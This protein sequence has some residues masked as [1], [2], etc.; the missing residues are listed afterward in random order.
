MKKYAIIRTFNIGDLNDFAASTIIKSLYSY[1]SLSDV[2]AIGY[3]LENSIL[4]ETEDPTLKDKIG[5][6]SL[7][8]PFA[9]KEDLFEAED[10]D[11]AKLIYEVS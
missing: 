8:G 11:S 6:C 3:R 5:H 7:R 1:E 2:F 9:S 4:I 10:E